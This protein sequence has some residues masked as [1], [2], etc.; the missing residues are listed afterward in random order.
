MSPKT[1]LLESVFTFFAVFFGT[2]LRYLVKAIASAPRL[3]KRATFET[4]ARGVGL[5]LTRSRVVP[6]QYQHRETCLV[7]EAF[8]V[9]YKLG[10][11]TPR[12]IRI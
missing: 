1:L 5:D 4:W 8:T 2:L 11:S 7:W 3:G 6:I 12:E 10:I 9:G